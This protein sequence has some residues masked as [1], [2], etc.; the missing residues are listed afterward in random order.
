VPNFPKQTVMPMVSYLQCPCRTAEC[1]ANSWVQGPGLFLRPECV[2][3]IPSGAAV[4]SATNNVT[5]NGVSIEHFKDCPE[6]GVSTKPDFET[7][8]S[9][10][11][12]APL[13]TDDGWSRGLTLTS[14]GA[15]NVK[16][17]VVQFT[18]GQ[19]VDNPGHCKNP[20]GYAIRDPITLKDSLALLMSALMTQQLVD[21]HLSGSCDLN[22]MPSVTGVIV[23]APGFQR[24]SLDHRTSRCTDTP[25]ASV[26]VT[27]SPS[28]WLT[29]L[30]TYASQQARRG[31]G[32]GNLRVDILVR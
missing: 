4:N 17:Q 15:L 22:G 26:T 30:E 7:R 23:N 14:V 24:R 5:L 3:G 29:C 6:P 19:S 8:E 9:L 31:E 16:G 28:R 27:Q 20:T 25:A 13:V 10:Q 11:P 2:H 21:I 32:K 12:S 1:S 18:V